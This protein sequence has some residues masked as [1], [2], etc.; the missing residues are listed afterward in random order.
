MA[1]DEEGRSRAY[2]RLADENI[3]ASPVHLAI[4]REEQ[5]LSGVSFTYGDDERRLMTGMTS[6]EWLPLQAVVKRARLPRH[7]VVALL[8]RLVRYGVV[9]MEHRDQQFLFTLA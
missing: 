6:G 1:I 4:W 7:K 3:L 9:L 8:A 2:V 5:S